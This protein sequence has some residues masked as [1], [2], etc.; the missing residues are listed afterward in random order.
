MRPPA[1][2]NRKDPALHLAFVWSAFF[3]LQHDRPLGF[4]VVG[5]IPFTAIDLYARRYDLAGSDAFERF[6][7]LICSMDAVF[8]AWVNKPQK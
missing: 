8:V 6:H 3:A 4:G 1:L 7:L 2:E 5:R